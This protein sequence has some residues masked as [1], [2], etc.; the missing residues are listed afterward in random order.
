MCPSLSVHVKQSFLL[1]CKQQ[2]NPMDPKTLS[3]ESAD[4]HR[5]ALPV[6]CL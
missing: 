1:G 3:L 4:T 5:L 6:Q 2:G